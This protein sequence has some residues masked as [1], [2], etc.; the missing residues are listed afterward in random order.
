VVNIYYRNESSCK[1]ISQLIEKVASGVKAA[2]TK[3]LVE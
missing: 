1:F 3:V 2:A